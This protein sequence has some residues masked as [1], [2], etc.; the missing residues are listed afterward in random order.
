MGDITFPSFQQAGI[1]T[2][3]VTFNI[4]NLYESGFC[5]GSMDSGCRRF[6]N[7]SSGGGNWGQAPLPLPHSRRTHNLGKIFFPYICLTN[8]T[9]IFQYFSQFISE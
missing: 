6:C 2:I 8:Y 4:F 9:D 3:E 7:A 1:K 5:D